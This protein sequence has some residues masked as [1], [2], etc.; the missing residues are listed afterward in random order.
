MTMI[1][2][3]DDN[4]VIFS[5]HKYEETKRNKKRL[6]P[7]LVNFMKIFFFKSKKGCNIK[8]HGINLLNS[9]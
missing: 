3:D 5:R 9:I 6:T 8:A 2:A 7:Y 1:E 4:V